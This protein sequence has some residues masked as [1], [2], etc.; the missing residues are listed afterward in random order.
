M[1]LIVLIASMLPLLANAGTC[2]G[3]DPCTACHDCTKCQFCAVQKK[4]SCGV[5]RNHTT[6]QAAARTKKLVASAAR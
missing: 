1:K 6:A 5:C 4:G 2:T 3:K